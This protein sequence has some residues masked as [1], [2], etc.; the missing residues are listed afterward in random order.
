MA[1][2]KGI[3]H[4]SPFRRPADGGREFGKLHR[5]AAAVATHLLRPTLKAAIAK[6]PADIL[7]D[8]PTAP[9]NTK[10]AFVVSVEFWADQ[11]S[12]WEAMSSA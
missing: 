3:V 5:A 2:I 9:E 6:V 4:T 8:L 7:A 1:V 11:R 10:T 12:T